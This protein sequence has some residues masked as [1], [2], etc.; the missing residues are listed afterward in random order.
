MVEDVSIDLADAVMDIVKEEAERFP[1]DAP[2]AAAQAFA[3]VRQLPDWDA[4][5]DSVWLRILRHFVYQV[6]QRT[7]RQIRAK[8]GYYR[9]ES[10]VE[11]HT[12]LVNTI[13][14]TVYE[15]N[16]TGST[17]GEL[18]L[19]DLEAEA[20]RQEKLIRAHRFNAQLLR[21]LAQDRRVT[22]VK[23]A[24][25]AKVSDVFSM[26]QLWDFF[27]RLGGLELIKEEGLQVS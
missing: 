23:K 1:A 12:D 25:G 7:N 6:R 2:E 27:K 14:K 19:A 4:M 5:T 24:S 8:A 18:L 3:R 10:R 22:D 26:K 20:E 13:H 21:A 16:L 15:Y 17:L 11:S 9:A